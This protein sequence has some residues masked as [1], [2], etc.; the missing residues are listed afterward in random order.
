MVKR[1]AQKPEA[2]Q[3]KINNFFQPKKPRKPEVVPDSPRIGE[4]S[5]SSTKSSSA[6]R[7]RLDFGGEDGDTHQ[8]MQ[9]A[10]KEVQTLMPGGQAL[11]THDRA[12]AKRPALA[13]EEFGVSAGKPDGDRGVVSPEKPTID[14]ATFPT[15]P[16]TPTSKTGVSKKHSDN[17]SQRKV[18]PVKASKTQE[19]RQQSGIKAVTPTPSRRLKEP[20]TKHK[21]T[22][23]SAM[24]PR[25]LAPLFSQDAGTKKDK[26]KL[27]WEK[28]RRDLLEKFKDNKYLL[29][30]HLGQLERE[31]DMVSAAEPKLNEGGNATAESG[32]RSVQ[33]TAEQLKIAEHPPHIP[34]SVRAGA[35]TGKTQTMVSRAVKLVTLHGLDPA[36]LLMLTF[37]KKAAGEMRERVK[38]E[39]SVVA[40][41]E[42]NEKTFELPTV[43]TF[44]SLAYSWIR[45]FWKQCGLGSYPSLLV[46]KAQ[47]KAFMKEVI[48]S[49]IKDSQLQRCYKFLGLPPAETRASWDTVIRIVKERF[50]EKYARARARGEADLSAKNGKKQGKSQQQQSASPGSNQQKPTA[51]QGSKNSANPSK[52]KQSAAQ[53][54]KAAELELLLQSKIQRHCYLE[55][56]LVSRNNAKSQVE[57]DIER[58]WGGEHAE[59]TY[60]KLVERARLGQHNLADYLPKDEAI[61]RRYENMQVRTGKIDFDKMLEL[62]GG[63]LRNHEW[64]ANMFHNVFDYVIVDEY[65]D[66]SKVQS[67]L[68]QQIVKKGGVTVVGDDDQCIYAFRG[69]WPGNFE[70]FSGYYASFGE[71]AEAKLEENYRSTGNI[72]Q[73]GGGF[74]EDL[75]KPTRKVLRPTRGSGEK[76][77]L[78]TCRTAES[79]ARQI[80]E[81]I[82]KRHDGNDKVQWGDTACL[83]RCFRMGPQ[84]PLHYALQQQLGVLKIPYKI[85][86]GQSLLAGEQSCD[87]LAYLTLTLTGTRE[88]MNDDAFARVLNK[89]SRKIGNKA[90]DLIK[91]HQSAMTAKEAASKPFDVATTT[92]CLEEAGRALLRLPGGDQVLSKSQ[93]DGL[94]KFFQLIGELRAAALSRKLPDLL[95]FIWERTGLHELHKN[96]EK[97]KA[98]KKDASKGYESYKSNGNEEKD[99]ASSKTATDKP[100]LTAQVKALL[101]VAEAHVR[102]RVRRED[103]RS[104]SIGLKSLASLASECLMKNAAALKHDQLPQVVLPPLLLDELYMEGGIGLATVSSFLED[105]ALQMDDTEG[106]LDGKQDNRVTLCTIHRAKGLEWNDVYVPFFNEEYMPTSFQDFDSHYLPT[107]HQRGCHARVP[108]CVIP[109]SMNCKDYYTCKDEKERGITAEDLHMDE[110]RR[111]AHV[112]ATRAKNRLVFVSTYED[113]NSRRCETSSFDSELPARIIDRRNVGYFGG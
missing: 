3:G 17:D 29:E 65:Q 99:A 96:K 15:T 51:K 63:L 97:K 108:G 5:A 61:L 90:M 85:V 75:T 92:V 20:E 52:R 101:A 35:G 81:S 42:G 73:A 24:S 80:A 66:N 110:E 55:L 100:V 31:R 113:N 74:L 102:E 40:Q 68:L 107:R 22:K 4:V 27:N 10:R 46:T 60:L 95:H 109:C 98:D 13:L 37:T 25:N 28:H 72:L 23:P 36:K 54:Q 47:Q 9:N 1:K 6:A 11:C 21:S 38:S 88:R 56:L 91:A 12:T 59:T 48:H 104:Q 89:P 30:H 41:Q 43:K 103:R 112:A 111:L 49:H 70:A 18:T 87:V 34:L 105:M 39:F 7:R 69:A 82:R 14:R 106:G 19:Q 79:Q 62:F 77:A 33:L 50:P 26:D 8:L 58:Q 57:C 32:T 83:F 86:G 78:W 93:L 76:V 64:I 2:G 84:A 44:H 71:V 67:E 53:K 94:E 16:T 45:P